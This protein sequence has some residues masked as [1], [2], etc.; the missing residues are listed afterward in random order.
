[1]R[2]HPV[3][4][5]ALWFVLIVGLLVAMSLFYKEDGTGHYKQ[6]G[7]F[8]LIVTSILTICL[9]IVATSKFWFSHLWKRN[10]THA[11]H[12]DHTEHHPEVRQCNFRNQ[13]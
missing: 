2:P 3:V 1:M 6:Q 13:R 7:I 4:S 11:R 10:S 12:H 8:V 5:I 9:T